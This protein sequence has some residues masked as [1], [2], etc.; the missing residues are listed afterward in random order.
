MTDLRERFRQLDRLEAPDLWGDVR[1]RAAQPLTSAS[2]GPVVAGKTTTRRRRPASGPRWTPLLI[3]LGILVAGVTG[4]VLIAGALHDDKV[5][6][7]L[8]SPAPAASPEV[9]LAP[10]PSSSPGSLPDEV[11]I[12][13]SANPR[14][15]G[16]EFGDIYLLAGS[17]APRLIIG[18]AGDDLAQGCPRFSPDG[19]MLAYGESDV[20]GPVNTYRGQWPVTRRSV[21]V[22][23]LDDQGNPLRTVLRVLLSEPSG[24][25][26]C[27][28]WSP[29]GTRLAALTE[30][31]LWVIDVSGDTET[32]PV[33]P[34]AWWEKEL[35]WSPDGSSIAVAE[36]GQIAVI[37]VDGG[38]S[39][40]LPV[41]EGGINNRASLGWT[42]D[43]GIIFVTDSG[44]HSIDVDSGKDTVLR[45][46][47]NG[48]TFLAAVISP[49]RAQVA[50][51]ERQLRCSSDSCAQIATRLLV[52]DTDGSNEV[53]MHV[54]PD[55]LG[56]DVIW[57][58]DGR[59][60]L[61]GPLAGIVS[62]GEAPDPP[63]VVLAAEDLNLEWSSS[64]V[65]WRPAVP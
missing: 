62:F 12:A 54:P 58:P 2:V 35:E 21:V 40:R 30:S 24:V 39:T 55:F 10:A 34:Y 25:P 42:S 11:Q 23:E 50:Y 9:S 57:S 45:S 38:V 17:D 56:S 60:L 7:V 29:D 49:D 46:D 16:G 52:M 36:L 63:L 59:H 14:T 31:A 48:A 41:D 37:G 6:A 26:L 18:S 13:V 1:R 15:D 4:T 53:E 64:E 33:A 51:V 32:F 65:S 27:P 22:V 28:E 61:M 44:L 8:P 43:G 3:A 5:P 47:A 19:R 20:S